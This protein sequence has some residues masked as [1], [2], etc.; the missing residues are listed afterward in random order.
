M[1]A[2]A[3]CDWRPD[4]E[5]EAPA[6]EQLA[7]HA[8]DSGHRLCRCCSRSLTDAEASMVGCERC[9]TA[10]RT[11]LA[12][13]HA[14]WV[15]LPAHL[16]H[17]RSAGFN[18][19]RVS[20]DGRPL[21]GGDV[22]V[23]LG[24]G[25]QGLS[26]DGVTSREGDPTSVAFELGWWEQ[27]LREEW[28]EPADDV[29][30]R[31]PGAVVRDAH[32]YLERRMRQAA[33]GFAGF[34]ELASDLKSLHVRLER[35]TGRS[36]RQI[37]AEAECFECGSDALV[38]EVTDKGLADVWTCQRCSEIYDWARYLLACRQRISDQPAAGW[39]LPEHV[40]FELDVPAQTVRTWAKRGLVA[41][42]CV[43]GDRRMRVWFEDAR[44]RATRRTKRSA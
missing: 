32:G 25:S 36:Q 44:D 27:A 20:G 21:P 1:S 6:R 15:E 11:N 37:R 9:L 40:A 34:D 31:S 14:M 24:P 33:V 42:A 26:E 19:G 23:L 39:S 41:V 10:A 16:G 5:S 7:E 18:D 22:L 30:P 2:C 13:I 29:R 3:R 8:Q 43:V 4:R 38:R 28:G 35:A 17:V 12:G